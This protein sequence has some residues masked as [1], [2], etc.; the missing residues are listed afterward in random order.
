M[1]L[2]TLLIIVALIVVPGA[3]AVAKKHHLSAKSQT[4]GYA[5]APGNLDNGARS[6][7]I[8]TCSTAAAKWRYSD[9]QT[10]QITNY[11]VCMTNHGQPFE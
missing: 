9:W 8:E 10:A 6:E 2:S 7:A 11:R 4:P 5:Y 1:K 3:Q